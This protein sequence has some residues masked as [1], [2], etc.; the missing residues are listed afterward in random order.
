MGTMGLRDDIEV[1]MMNGMDKTPVARVVASLGS[2]QRV[3]LT[4]DFPQDELLA[5]FARFMVNT[6]SAIDRLAAVVESLQ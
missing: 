1:V 6:S 3:D 2:G 4:R 5:M